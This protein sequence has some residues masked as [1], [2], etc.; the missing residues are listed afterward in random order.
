MKKSEESFDGASSG[1]ETAAIMAVP[2]VSCRQREQVS[3]VNILCWQ[4]RPQSPS[5]QCHDG[6]RPCNALCSALRK[7][8]SK[9]P[10]NLAVARDN[11]WRSRRFSAVA[12]SHTV[13]HSANLPVR[14]KLGCS[15]A[16]APLILDS[17]VTSTPW[18]PVPLQSSAIVKHCI[19]LL[20]HALEVPADAEIPDSDLS[21]ETC[22]ARRCRNTS[23]TFA[24]RRRIFHL[25]ATRGPHPP[26]QARKTLHQMKGRGAKWCRI[27]DHA[28]SWR[29]YGII[30]YL[31][32]FV[33]FASA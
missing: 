16:A 1:S 20:T 2:Q 14:Q 8:C 3:N 21:G 22:S 27:Y 19:D 10:R 11:R 33:A 26:L 23:P 12:E 7:P 32:A 5:V 18:I 25:A 15:S 17:L 9:R 4:R 30:R 24:V 29:R 31:S 6:L 28:Q 13:D